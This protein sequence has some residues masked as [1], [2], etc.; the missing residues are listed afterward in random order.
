MHAYLHL[1]TWHALQGADLVVQLPELQALCVL[2]VQRADQHQR[3]VLQGQRSF[4]RISYTRF[5]DPAG[6]LSEDIAHTSACN[7][8]WGWV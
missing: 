7:G 2:Q 3:H 8:L 4:T 5:T 6:M 1:V